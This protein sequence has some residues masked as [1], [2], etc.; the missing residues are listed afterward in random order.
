MSSKQLKLVLIGAL[1]LIIGILFTCEF[2]GP[3]EPPP[4]PLQDTIFL[5]HWRRE[6]K[7]KQEIVK[8]HETKLKR[9]QSTRDSLLSDLAKQKKALSAVRFKAQILQE[10]LRD[11]VEKADSTTDENEEILPLVDSVI[12]ANRQSDTACDSE[13]IILERI[14]ANRDSAVTQHLEIESQLKDIN[15]RQEIDNVFLTGQ[16][17]STK[18]DLRQCRRRNKLI[19]AGLFFLSGIT[20]TLI[21]KNYL[22]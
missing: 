4:T 16:L 2:S 18:K 7:E 8:A 22:K 14:I 21:I 1:L 9:L 17:E 15:K 6:K 3:A 20:T 12:S 10:R 11:K 13:I 19:K 5:N